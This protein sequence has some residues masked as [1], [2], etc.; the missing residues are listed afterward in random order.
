[1]DSRPIERANHGIELNFRGAVHFQ[2]QL[3]PPIRISPIPGPANPDP[4]LQ[5]LQEVMDNHYQQ[6]F[7]PGGVP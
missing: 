3:G 5:N 6:P 4:I 2:R 1:M 7:Y